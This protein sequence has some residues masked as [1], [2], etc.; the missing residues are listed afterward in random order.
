MRTKKVLKRVRTLNLMTEDSV[1]R[2]VAKWLKQKRWKVTDIA[3]GHK[4][5]VDVRAKRGV[6]HWSIEAKGC[7]AHSTAR[8][9]Y[10][11][12]VLGELLQNM[13]KRNTKYSLAFP[14]IPQFKRLWGRLPALAKRRLRLTALFVSRRRKVVEVK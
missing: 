14:D 7:G 4:R 2:A 9:N 10:F 11:V 5:G 8:T 3:M 1:K 6:I 12:S 13:S